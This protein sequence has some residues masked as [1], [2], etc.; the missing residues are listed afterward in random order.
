MAVAHVLLVDGVQRGLAQREGDFDE[1]VS[2]KSSFHMFIDL[3]ALDNLH[4]S[5]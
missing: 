1:A 4:V 5:S 2:H 3:I